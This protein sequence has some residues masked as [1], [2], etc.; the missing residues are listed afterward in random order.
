MLVVALAAALAY[1]NAFG[2]QFVYDDIL[3]IRDNPRIRS[4]GNVPGFF[5]SSYWGRAGAL[6]LYRPLVVTSYAL[7]FAIGG[8][9][10]YGYT[11]V[12]IALHAGASV[13]VFVLA[14]D[15]GAPLAACAAAGLLFAAHPVHAEAVAGIIGRSE[16]MAAL[17]F[18]AAVLL[19]RRAASA[20]RA[21]RFRAGVLLC[22]AGA[23]MSKESAVTLVAALP[24]LDWLVPA[25]DASGRP[26]PPKA[27][28]VRD[29]LPVLAVAAAFVLA[30]RAVLGDFSTEGLAPLDNPMVALRPMPFGPPMGSTRGEAV[31]TAFAVVTEYAR[32]LFWPARLSADY[33]Y[34]QITTARSV[35]DPR[36]LAGAAIVV[37]C[38]A[39]IVLLRRRAPVAAA[40]LA[41]LAIAYSLTSNFVV[42]VAAPV[43]TICA[44]RLMYLPSAG[45]AIVVG[46]AADA[47][48]R[49][50]PPRR[51]L[52]PLCA[53]T[54]VLGLAASR[55]W[56]RNRDW[57]DEAHLWSSAMEAAPDSA[58]VHFEYCG[59]SRRIADDLAAAGMRED[60]RALMDEARQACERALEIYPSY[61]NPMVA[62]ATIHAGREEYAEALAYLDKALKISPH[63]AAALANRGATLYDRGSR[64]RKRA[65]AVR[66]DGRAD[67]A[68][69]LD[70]AAQRDMA[71]ALVQ[72]EAAIA[73]QPAHAHAHLLRALVAREYLHDGAAALRS[74]EEVLRLTPARVDRPAIEKAISEL[75]GQASGSP[76]PAGA[77]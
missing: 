30:R 27:R 29:Y 31:L 51:R 4:L 20:P 70:A 65:A 34:A 63:D 23:L 7:N 42:V 48:L 50:T 36:V 57:K 40:G 46:V 21:G 43:S 25:R 6:A 54:I 59:I 64:Q 10:T 53:S 37:A 47:L 17:L 16:V 39:G 1:A 52:A 18:L 24:V 9:S 58:R 66:A 33:S 69:A 73:A 56:A 45:F 3:V 68:A 19:H 67:E 71:D 62:L 15:L 60:S 55:T 35:T 76:T 12:N 8:L 44:E 14:A 75:R 41:V 61:P 22:F 26:V 11:A 72:V 2:N 32:L 49:A 28:F 13:L 77:R 38:L 5:A 74:F